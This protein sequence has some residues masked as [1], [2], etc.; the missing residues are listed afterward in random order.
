ML[1]SDSVDRIH[2]LTPDQQADYEAAIQRGES[3]NMA[4]IVAT[5]QAPGGN[6]RD[7]RW[8]L[9]DERETWR[10]DVPQGKYQAGLARYPGD[11]RAFVQSRS[12]A[13]ALARKMGR[14]IHDGPVNHDNPRQKR[15][16]VKR[17]W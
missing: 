15:A 3:H 6:F 4:L 16:E 17:S 13:A 2:G 7:E 12:E 5:Q 9:S 11:K 1:G 14:T 8:R 10:T